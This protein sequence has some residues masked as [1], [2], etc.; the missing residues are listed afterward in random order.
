MVVSL[1]QILFSEILTRKPM[2]LNSPP[3]LVQSVEIVRPVSCEIVF[4]T[5][6]KHVRAFNFLVIHNTNLYH[7]ELIQQTIY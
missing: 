5:C 2:L 6:W 3:Q 4:K 1:L 7:V